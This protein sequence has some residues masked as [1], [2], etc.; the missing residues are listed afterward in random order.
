MRSIRDK[1][2]SSKRESECIWSQA[3]VI[4][5]QACNNAYDC[6]ACDLDHELRKAISEN[7]KLKNSEKKNAGKYADVVHWKDKLRKQPLS[8]QYCLRYM[9]GQ[10][11]LK[12]CTNDYNCINCDFDQFFHDQYSVHTAIQPVDMLNVAGFKVPQGYYY[13][14][15]HTWAKIEQNSEV[16]IGIDDF[17]FK[18]LGTPDRIEGP[19]VGKKVTQGKAAITFYRDGKTARFLSPVSGIV[20][21]VNIKLCEQGSPIKDS[22]YVEGWIMRVHATDLRNDLK[23]LRLGTEIKDHMRQ[24]IELL[25]KLIE[26]Q[27]QLQAADGGFLVDDIYG[28]MPDLGWE[29]LTAEFL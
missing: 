28:T 8:R 9:K 11:D 19:L 10:I 22:P 12:T 5:Y 23:S 25:Q 7:K 20:S 21:A 29:R 3:G 17:A 4:D 2:R 16:R 1:K 14:V 27:G 6:N 18:L 13:H 15:G 26:E 24:D